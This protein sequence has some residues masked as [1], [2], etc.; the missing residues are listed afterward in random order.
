MIEADPL[1]A[2]HPLLRALVAA[3]SNYEITH[4]HQVQAR[5]YNKR[6]LVD[7]APS[8]CQ[9]FVRELV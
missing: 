7:I 1:Q 4:I 9:R 5:R 3:P 8:I 2:L 6:P